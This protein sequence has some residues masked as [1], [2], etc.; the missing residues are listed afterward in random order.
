[1]T[2]WHFG[3]TG[4]PD[5]RRGAADLAA[6]DAARAMAVATSVSSIGSNALSTIL[7]GSLGPGL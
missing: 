7:S 6:L 2:K 4:T 1:M 3:L 5:G